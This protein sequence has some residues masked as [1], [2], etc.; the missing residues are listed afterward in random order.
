MNEELIQLKN[1][2]RKLKGEILKKSD[3][4]SNRLKTEKEISD[5][6]DWNMAMIFKN[7]KNHFCQQITL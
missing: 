5:Y 7:M 2:G 3:K 4:N 6:S 1:V